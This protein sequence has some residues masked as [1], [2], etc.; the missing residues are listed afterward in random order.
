VRQSARAYCALLAVAGLALAVPRLSATDDNTQPESSPAS[1]IHWTPGPVT[2]KL[3]DN[4]EIAVPPD[5]LFTDGDG[6]RRVLEITHNPPSNQEVGLITPKAK[7]ETWFIIFEFKPVGYIKDD[8]KSSLDA[9]AIL[10][11]IKDATEESNEER[12]KHGWEAFHI[13]SWYMQPFYDQDTHNL[14]WAVNGAEDNGVNP[15]V[16]YSVRVLG[17]KGTMNVDLVLDPNDMARVEPV[18]K[19]IMK[20]F[21]FTNGNRYADF[22][23]GDKLAGYGLTALIAGGAGAVAVKTGL[24]AKLWKLIVTLIAAAWK[25]I[26]VVFAAVAAFLRRI[27][28][29]I[30]SVF[31]PD[32]QP[33]FPPADQ[34]GI[35]ASPPVPTDQPRAAEAESIDHAGR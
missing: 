20:S 26:V 19:S 13:T 5:F 2:V 17:R 16:N 15:S 33:E 23:R 34:Q 29:K 31:G 10:K 8:E 27:W 3:G 35:G 32:R 14:T 25:L 18:F 28:G 24:L 12:K 7:K 9:D 11:N 6:T 21:R 1:R 30:K 22:A 4:A